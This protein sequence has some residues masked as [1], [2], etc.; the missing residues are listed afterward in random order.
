M[1]R[2]E[3]ENIPKRREKKELVIK[4]GITDIWREGGG[5]GGSGLDEGGK[6]LC[7]EHCGS[8][9]LNDGIGG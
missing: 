6:S 7:D 5:A 4:I 3:K 2:K 9:A 8:R 1:G